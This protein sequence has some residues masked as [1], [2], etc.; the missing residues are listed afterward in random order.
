MKR[1]RI[2]PRAERAEMREVSPDDVTRA[3]RYSV[4]REIVD[5]FWASG[6]A[7]AELDIEW[8]GTTKRKRAERN[9]V[10]VTLRHHV[11]QAGYAV[12]VAGRAGKIFLVREEADN[13]AQD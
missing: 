12:R 7:A 11:Q 5:N 13:G 9:A 4:Y 1:H 3:G 10:A 2:A 8:R 6:M